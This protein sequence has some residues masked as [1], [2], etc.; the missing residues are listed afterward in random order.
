MGQKNICDCQQIVQYQRIS[1]RLQRIEGI[2]IKRKIKKYN[3]L[4]FCHLYFIL[5][6]II[7]PPC[8]FFAY[9]IFPYP[10]PASCTVKW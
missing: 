8:I 2:S 1:G 5:S 10:L 7:I 3:L 9:S 4:K 6:L